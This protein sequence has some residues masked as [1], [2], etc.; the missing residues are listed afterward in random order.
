MGLRPGQCYR[1]TEKRPYSR[2][3][4][5]VHRRNYIGATPGLRTRQ[6]NMGNTNK[7][8]TNILDLI[9]EETVQIRDNSIESARMNINRHLQTKL[10]KDGFFMK[11]RIYPYNI[12]R[13]NKQAQGAHADRIQT[14]MSKAFG[15]PIG[16]AAR[17]RKGQK[18]LSVL[19]DEPDVETAK[20]A[21]MGS[22][23]RFTCQI[24]VRVGT[25]VETIGTKPKKSRAMMEEKKAEETASNEKE[26]KGKDSKDAK[27]GKGK[28]TKSE[29]KDAKSK[30][31]KD[32]KKDEKK[33]GKK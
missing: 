27:G 33:S 2:Y 12:L 7:N 22:K 18:I 8:F 9:A 1:S 25:D 19:V 13:E 3:A 24:S 10:G 30:D 26:E 16:R 11:I 5:K 31:G 23:S 28:D 15:K 4:V 14:G 29:G 20:K 21:L 17:V 6:F 32:T